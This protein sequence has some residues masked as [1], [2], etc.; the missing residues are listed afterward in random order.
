MPG[1]G[2]GG[3]HKHDPIYLYQYLLA[4]F[5]ANFSLNF[6]RKRL[7]CEKN[8]VVPCLDVIMIAFL[9]RNMH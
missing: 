4:L 3:G 1:G 7:Q 6:P 9:P 2:G 5:R 8:I